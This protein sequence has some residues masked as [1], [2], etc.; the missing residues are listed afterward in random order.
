MT[1][2]PDIHRVLEFHE[3]L[4]Q[5]QAIER[6]THIPGTYRQENDT[7]HSYNLAMMAWFLAQYFPRLDRDKIIR[8]AL[9][10]DLVE[11][12]A[13]DTYIYADAA[14][15]ATKK[16]RE[17]KALEQLEKDWSDFND[18]IKN[19]KDYETHTSEEARFVYALD[20]IMPILVIYLAEGYTWKQEG[21]TPEQLDEIKRHKIAVSDDISPYYEELYVLLL[22]NRHYFGGKKPA[23]G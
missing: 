13:G 1:K 23:V 21:I 7:E 10:H 12:H 4:L 6:I 3:L 9:V 11:V 8:F 2:K 16:K 5:F 15:L 17:E 19:V 14:T 22:K 20:K 18:L